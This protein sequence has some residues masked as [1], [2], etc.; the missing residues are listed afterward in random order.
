MN[1]IKKMVGILN[2]RTYLPL[3]LLVSVFIGC[4][5]NKKNHPQKIIEDNFLTLVDTFAY[6][7]GSFRPVGIDARSEEPNSVKHYPELSIFINKKIGN[8]NIAKNEIHNFLQKEKLDSKFKELTN[9][10]DSQFVLDTAFPKKIGRYNISFEPKKPTKIKYA[11][12]VAFSNF[13]ISEDLGY[14]IVELSDGVDSSIGFIVLIEKI[15]GIWKIIKREALY[16]T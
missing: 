13:K 15:D 12:E 6:E 11:G 3:I 1:I 7:Y 8:S 10:K 4:K 9:E 2:I 16:R 14:F 5:D